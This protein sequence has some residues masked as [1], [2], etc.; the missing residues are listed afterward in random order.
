MIPL[1]LLASERSVVCRAA[2]R[3]A[4]V[5]SDA[6]LAVQGLRSLMG[7]SCWRIRGELL[8]ACV[9]DSAGSVVPRMPRPLWWTSLDSGFRV[10][11]VFLGFDRQGWITVFAALLLALIMLYGLR[12]TA[13]TRVTPMST[14]WEPLPSIYRSKQEFLASLPRWR[15]LLHKLN[16]RP[17]VDLKVQRYAIE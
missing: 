4:P 10:A 13:S 5:S 7:C 6:F 2:S 1:P 15:R 14:S 16:W 12:P 3:A 17:T 11:T 9:C 8:H